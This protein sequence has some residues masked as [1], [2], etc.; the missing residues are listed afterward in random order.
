MREAGTEKRFVARMRELLVTLPYDLKVLFEAMSDQ[1]L[2]EEARRLAAGGV[3][4]CLSPSDPIPD[5]VGLVGLVDDAILVRFVL[6]R[7]LELGG[8]EAAGYPE[9]FPEQFEGLREDV[10]LIRD[11]L[12]DA[13]GW[14][15]ERVR[16]LP[17]GRYKGKTVAT[18]T[19][20]EDALQFLYEEGLEYATEYE[21]DDERA[22]RLTS[23]RPV[24]EA[25]Q[26][27]QQVEQAR[28]GR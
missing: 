12:G 18:Y 15:D 2:P 28:K 20:D 13:L 24:L 14:M 19:D 16:R 5:S 26:A 7:L 22:Q 21:V 6:E 4:Y 23:G 11:Y 9:R 8:D 3:I 17:E 27:R 25:F 10:A 1:N